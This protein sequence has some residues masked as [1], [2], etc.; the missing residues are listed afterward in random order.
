MKALI[1]KLHTIYDYIILD[2]PPVNVVSDALVVAPQTGGVV[3]VIRDHV[4][5]HSQISKA[6]KNI[7]FAG[8]NT[9]GLVLNDSK[10]AHKKSSRYEY[11]N[12]NANYN[13]NYNYSYTR[14]N[15][16]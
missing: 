6:L 9:L 8:S 1:E 4:T 11:R 16:E 14:S 10:S 12:E 2:A 3:F 13:Y 5:Q 7:R 15:K